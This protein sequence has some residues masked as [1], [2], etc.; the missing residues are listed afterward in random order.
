MRAADHNFIA[1]AVDF[2][3]KRMLDLVQVIILLAV[4]NGN[5]AIILKRE[6]FLRKLLGY[7]RSPSKKG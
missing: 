2:H 1:A 3:V 5:K 7:G 4:Q 6:A